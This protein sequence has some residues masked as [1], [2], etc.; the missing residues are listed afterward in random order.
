MRPNKEDQNT[1][2]IAVVS[3]VLGD[4]T[5]QLEHVSNEVQYWKAEA[6]AWKSRCEM[7]SLQ[8]Q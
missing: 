3:S 4:I 7:L 5:Q 1:F 6:K 2:S 8:L